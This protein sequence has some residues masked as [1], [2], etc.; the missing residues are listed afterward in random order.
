[1]RLYQFYRNLKNCSKYI[2]LSETLCEFKKYQS[3]VP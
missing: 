1:M 3:T 2:L